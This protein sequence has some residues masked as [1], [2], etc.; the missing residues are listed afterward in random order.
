LRFILDALVTLAALVIILYASVYADNLFDDATSYRDWVGTSTVVMLA[1]AFV[2]AFMLTAID[3]PP[4]PT[5]TLMRNTGI[6][7]K[8]HTHTD[9]FWCLYPD[10]GEQKGRLIAIPDDK[11]KALS[12]HSR[13]E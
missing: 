9:G 1:A 5:T 10:E 12:V 11:V 7:G 3:K 4:L 8:L 2:A 6:T 13:D